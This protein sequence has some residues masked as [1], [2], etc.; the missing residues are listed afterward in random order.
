MSLMQPSSEIIARIEAGIEVNHIDPEDLVV[1]ARRR[2]RRLDWERAVNMALAALLLVALAPLLA[3]V[4]L[5]VRFG[6]GGPVL[7]AHHRIGRDGR[8]FRCFKFRSMKVDAKERLERLLAEDAQARAEWDLDHKLKNDPR[9]TPFGAFLRKSSLDEL[10]QLFNVV[11]GEM[12]LVGPRPIV[13]DEARRYGRYLEVY[14]SV[15][16]GITGLWQVSGRN[17]VTYRRRVALDTV[18]VRSK[19]V[20]LDVWILLATVPVVLF[21]RG[22]Y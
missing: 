6:D 11:R 13:A 2:S 5:C 17:D 15:R 7:F 10:P 12:S 19:S 18:Y 21:R 4:A 14:Q 9:I 8:T 20:P 22:S 16:P 1:L 3:V